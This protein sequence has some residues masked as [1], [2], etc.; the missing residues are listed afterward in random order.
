M[1]VQHIRMKNVEA[2]TKMRQNIASEG[3]EGC[4]GEIK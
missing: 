2:D 3:S 1:K 4:V